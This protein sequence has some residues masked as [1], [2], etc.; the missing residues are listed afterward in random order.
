MREVENRTKKRVL[1]DS[2][3]EAETRARGHLVDILHL[4]NRD[5]L[6]D[7]AIKEVSEMVEEAHKKAIQSA[8]S[9]RKLRELNGTNKQT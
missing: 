7:S 9:E 6:S 3:E 4:L 1:E 2:I 8:D 5:K